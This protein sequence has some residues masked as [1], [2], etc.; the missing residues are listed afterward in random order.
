[1]E[2]NGVNMNNVEFIIGP[3]DSY[4]TRDYGP[5]WVVTEIILCRL[6]TSPIIDQDLR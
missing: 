2:N 4:W 5:W 1:M 6:W 3:T